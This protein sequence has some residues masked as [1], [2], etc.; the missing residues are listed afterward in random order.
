[1]TESTANPA[2]IHLDLDSAI[3]QVGDLPSVLGILVMVEETLQRDIPRIADLLADGKVPEAGRLLHSLKGFV[4]IF[5]RAAL[6]VHVT[7]V[8]ALSK[9]GSSADVGPAFDALKPELELLL[10]EVSACLRAENASI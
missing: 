2:P 7:K 9:H 3:S 1:M 4:P 8:E 5:C 6:C 10:S